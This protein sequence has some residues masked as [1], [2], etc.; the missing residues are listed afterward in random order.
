M[1]LPLL[2]VIPAGAGS[3]KTHSIQELL[4]EW[5]DQGEVKPENIVAV[6]FTETAAAELKQRISAK[7]VEKDKL[8]AAERL[9]QAYIST[10]HGFGLR[11]LSEFAFDA[12]LSPKQRLLNEDEQKE[13]I[14]K[15]LTG[16]RRAEPIIHRLQDYGYKTSFTRGDWQSAEEGFRASLLHL[17]TL[18][19][20]LGWS[21]EQE[22]CVDPAKQWLSTACPWVVKDGEGL[23]GRLHEAVLGLLAEFPQSL[24][25]E[26]GLNATAKKDFTSNFIDLGKAT[27]LQVLDSDWGLWKRLQLL[28]TRVQKATLPDEYVAL[29]Q[30]V[31]LA[32]EQLHVHPGPL[33]HELTHLDALLGAAEEVL[34]HYSEAKREAALLDYTDMIALANDLLA[35]RD[36]VFSVLKSRVDCVIVDEFQDTNPLQFSLVWLLTAAG[37]PTL[38]VGDVKQAIMGFQGADPRLF[39]SVQTQNPA[40]LEPQN[41]NWR[42]QQ[43]LME[44][45]NDVSTGLF[46][47]EYQR[48]APQVESTGLAP[49][50]VIEFDGKTDRS[51]DDKAWY[52]AH[53][54]EH[55][56]EIL[57]DGTSMVKDR[58]SG[59]LRA[60]KPGDIAVLAP[61]HALLAV[62]RDVLAAYGI[63]ASI[64][65]QGWYQGQVVQ[66]MTAALSY[67]ADDTDYHAALYLSVTAMGSFSLENALKCF[68]E[69]SIPDDPLL[70]KLDAC[71]AGVDDLS[72]P[73]I[74][75]RVIQELDLYHRILSWANADQER[76]NLLRFQQESYQ[77]VVIHK[78]TLASGGY[79]GSGTQTFLA[80]LK[81][82]VEEDDK[83]PSATVVDEDA[84]VLKTWHS[85]KGLE[86]PVVVVAGLFEP[87]ISGLPD[88]SIGYHSF[89]DLSRVLIEAQIQFS[90]NFDDPQTRDA[91]KGPL[92]T[93]ATIDAKRVLYVALTRAREKLILEWPSR[94]KTSQAKTPQ[95]W[96]VLAEA[97]AI[98]LEE[99]AINV[100]GNS[101]AC[102]IK[103]T[104]GFYPESYQPGEDKLEITIK[105]Y[106]RA[107][108]EKGVYAGTRTPVFITPSDLELES[109]SAANGIE[110]VEYG[111]GINIDLDL[112]ARDYGSFVHRCIERFM[113]KPD[114]KLDLDSVEGLALEEVDQQAIHAELS[115]F[116]QYI[117][118]NY[119]A[120][121]LLY[122]IPVNGKNEAG[123]IVSGVVDLLIEEDAGYWIIDHKS[124]QV[125]D[126]NAAFSTHL[127]QLMAYASIIDGYRDKP[128]LGIGINWVRNGQV[129]FVK[130]EPNWQQGA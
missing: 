27:D 4:F 45:L 73:D 113:Y 62:Y 123:A 70:E 89:D 9:D 41:Q 57:D 91:F 120:A 26:Y 34:E 67:L 65:Q 81:S 56:K 82:R 6:T 103:R 19:R 51:V 58:R 68:I 99:G 53:V 128:V 84:V 118:E 117:N 47:A 110:S 109:S 49:L 87:L 129:S 25:A 78:E 114:Q 93:Q 1:S 40:V 52:A 31:I 106:G 85:S 98:E 50:D 35:K 38:I 108:L 124:D 55:I 44:F 15:A 77:F 3:G 95:Y 20:S 100:N 116:R 96:K 125:G 2:K 92:L 64:D 12:G 10:I 80:W 59:E 39:E 18:L 75:G 127:S 107:A 28:R 94:L 11:I 43:P 111:A 105:G 63:N 74:V 112:S 48:L 30:E 8:E 13:L 7:L 36:D 101:F 21:D 122:E 24:T 17:V 29:A 5:I 37:I 104:D 60:L 90:P 88:Y 69:H 79:Y 66:I 33:Q 46:G 23:T 22:S 126:V 42:T 71:R 97:S 76:A 32:A 86:W 130:M 14:K 72:I 83:Q 119:P 16:T 61:R 121:N 54:V 115:N 102:R